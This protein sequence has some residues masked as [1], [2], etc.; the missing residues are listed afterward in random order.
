M[1]NPVTIEGVLQI[2]AADNGGGSG[3][4]KSVGLDGGDTGLT[5]S[6]GPVTTTGTITLGGTLVMPPLDLPQARKCPQRIQ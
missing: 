4:V 1:T 3:T 5:S 2:I 6:G